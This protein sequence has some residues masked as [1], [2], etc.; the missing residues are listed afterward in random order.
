MKQGA[1]LLSIGFLLACPTIASSCS[2]PYCNVGTIAPTQTYT[3]VD[4]SVDVTGSFYGFSANFTDY[5]RIYDVTTQTAGP[6][7]FDNQTAVAGDFGDFGSFGTGDTIVFELWDQ[8]T[9]DIFASDP[10]YSGDSQNHAYGY[11][12]LVT[13]SSGSVFIGMED[14]D[15]AQQTDWDYNDL[16]FFAYDVQMGNSGKV[17]TPEPATFLL[18]GAGILAGLS[19]IQKVKG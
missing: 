17:A 14:L 18:L 2:I 7:I 19:R 15:Q 3:V 11:N 9:N 5:V 1:L 10:A 13:I 12:T 6:W 8:N 4:G 16:E